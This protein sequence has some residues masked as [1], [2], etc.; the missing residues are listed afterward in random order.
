MTDQQIIKQTIKNIGPV[1]EM[2]PRAVLTHWDQM[3]KPLHSLGKL[4]TLWAQLA[5][6]QRTAHPS[7][8][9]RA[10][11]VFCADNG[12]VEE[13][14]SQTG[15]SV[16]ATVAENFFDQLTCTSI[17]CKK[18][19]CDPYVI[20]IGMAVDTPRTLRRKVAYGTKNM[21]KEPAMTR[22]EA[23]RA[24]VTGMELAKERHAAGYDLLAVGEMGIGNTTTSTA[25][26][27]VL[28]GASVEEM[29]GR[30]AG[31]SDAGFEKKKAVIR[32]A[33][34][35]LAPDASDPIDVLAKVGGFDLAGIAGA[36]IGAAACKVPVLLDGFISLAAALLAVRLAPNV[37]PYLIPTHLSREPAAKRLLQEL[38]MN[39]GICMDLC[40]GEGS[41]AVAFLPFLDMAQ[42]LYETMGSFSDIHVEQYED[43]T[44]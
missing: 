10:L 23:Y 20:D 42:E 44:C 3:G 43:Y 7:A 9:R 39:P 19:N 16:T 11:L 30:G 38:G 18:N 31:L 26:S 32:H 2:S 25:L 29:T 5:A 8:K 33:L 40:L 37:L 6:I 12:V 21:A 1:D 35:L 22:E 34:D 13:G 4:E 15:Q 17:L 14:V 28:L 41:G 27:A 24:I 36:C